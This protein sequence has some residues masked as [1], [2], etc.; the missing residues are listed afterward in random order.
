MGFRAPV[1]T[2]P[3]WG[4]NSSGPPYFHNGCGT[5]LERAIQCH[6]GEGKAAAEKFRS[7]PAADQQSLIAYLKSL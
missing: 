3:L 7:L 5:T 6:Q 4:L 1:V 2:A